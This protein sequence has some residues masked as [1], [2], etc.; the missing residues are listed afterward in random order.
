LV[1][2][3]NTGATPVAL[4]ARPDWDAAGGLDLEVVTPTGERRS[5]GAPAD[6]GT[7]S[8]ITEKPAKPLV[9]APGQSFGLFRQLEAGE[10]FRIAGTYRLM[11]TY[12]HSGVTTL[13][14]EPVDI[15]IR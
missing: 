6:M 5:L 1:S 14:S 3:T 12:R 4:P 7:R 13:V 9:L 11:A 2:I 10:L 15:T 8:A